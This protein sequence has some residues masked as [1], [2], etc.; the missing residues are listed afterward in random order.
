MRYADGCIMSLR[1]VPLH[2][3]VPV[4]NGQYLV[5]S[6]VTG[7]SVS[8]DHVTHNNLL[9]FLAEVRVGLT[10]VHV[11]V[12]HGR[13]VFPGAQKLSVLL[14]EFFWWFHLFSFCYPLFKKLG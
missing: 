9:D 12:R 13:R 5:G 1:I 2:G 10:V 8:L 6:V 4:I 7:V 14:W 11:M 3:H